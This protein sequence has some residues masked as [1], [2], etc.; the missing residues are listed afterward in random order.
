MGP[1]PS[2]S[3]SAESH[4]LLNQMIKSNC[5]FDESNLFQKNE[6][7]SIVISIFVRKIKQCW[8]CCV[9]GIS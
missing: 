1:A 5:V 3:P 2:S 9:F 7:N 8:D 4:F 6:T